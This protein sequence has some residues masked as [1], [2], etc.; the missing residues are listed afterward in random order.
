MADMLDAALQLAARGLHVFPCAPRQK[1]PA[2]KNGLKAATVDENQIRLWWRN[3]P[4][5]NIG[6]ACGR[7]S[8]F[9]VVDIDGDIAE[10]EL[11]RLQA[12]HGELPATVESKTGRGRHLLF[13]MPADVDVK[14]SAGKIAN[15]I[16]VRGSG[17]YIL[18]WPSVHPSGAIYTWSKNNVS[19]F[20]DAPAWLLEL[21]V[22][23]VKSGDSGTIF[24]ETRVRTTRALFTLDVGEGGRNH[25]IAKIAGYLLR[26]IPDVYVARELL[27]AW[28]ATHCK[29]PLDERELKITFNSICGKELQRMEEEDG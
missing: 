29:P 10:Q 17:G 7:V 16:D 26:K 9:F 22:T 12:Q 20:Q 24:D 15:K 2:V 8:G 3:N 11:A 23:P 5:L 4:A 27:F 13:R 1:I 6:V 21:V 25:R 28:N 18:V 19:G 14:N